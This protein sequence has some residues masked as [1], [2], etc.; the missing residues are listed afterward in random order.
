MTQMNIPTKQKQTHTK[1]EQA[2]CC[3]RGAGEGGR[4]WEFGV[5]G[6]KLLYIEWI[7]KALP[8][9]TENYIQYPMKP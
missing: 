8:C 3:Q 2:H 7:N 4:G 9:S 5:N 1:R 6:Y